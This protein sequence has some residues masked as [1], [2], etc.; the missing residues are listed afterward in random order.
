MLVKAALAGSILVVWLS[1]L[2][3]LLLLNCHWPQ[4]LSIT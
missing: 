4:A 2:T 3:G 1:Q